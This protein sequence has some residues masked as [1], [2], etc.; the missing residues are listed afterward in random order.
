MRF[1]FVSPEPRS[2]SAKTKKIFKNPQKSQTPNSQTWFNPSLV[3]SKF[4]L[5]EKNRLGT[6]LD[7]FL[8]I[9]QL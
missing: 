4:V 1:E 5:I 6:F 3:S 9:Y 2:K 8:F 7:R